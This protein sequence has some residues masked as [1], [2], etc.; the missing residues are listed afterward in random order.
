MAKQE[1]ARPTPLAALGAVL[2]LYLLS[3]GWAR[4][5]A[6]HTV[7]HYTGVDGKGGARRDYIAKRD[8][9][10]GAGWEVR[11]FLPAIMAEEA[12]RHALQTR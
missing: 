4:T 5:V 7:E 3:Y 11:L 6:L 8:Q 10:P 9:P 1:R 2:G 12:L